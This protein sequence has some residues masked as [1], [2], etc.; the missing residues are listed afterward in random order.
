MTEN[1]KEKFLL[2]VGRESF[3]LLSCSLDIVKYCQVRDAGTLQ[4][5]N[6]FHIY[7]LPDTNQG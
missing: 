3:F 2:E 6:H 1:I 4:S 5:V 7:S